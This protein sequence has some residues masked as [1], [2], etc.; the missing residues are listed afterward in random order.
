MI[1]ESGVLQR[2]KH[3]VVGTK[4]VDYLEKKYFGF[5]FHYN[6]LIP[7][8]R[9]TVG[10]MNIVCYYCFL[11]TILVDLWNLDVFSWPKKRSILSCFFF[12]C[13]PGFFY[14]ARLATCTIHFL[15]LS[16]FSHFR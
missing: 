10:L 11:Q 8:N 1:E 2:V 4:M 16:D 6:F 5:Q 7:R 12:D 9:V 14:S 3:V 13:F 15:S